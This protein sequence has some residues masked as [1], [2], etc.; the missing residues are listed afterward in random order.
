MTG[1]SIVV[2]V[3]NALE[4]ARKCI[5]SV[6]T[7]RT[8]ILFEVIVVDNGS[9]PDVGTWLAEER[10]RRPNFKSL[11][12]DDPLGFAGAINAGVRH[13]QGDLI[14]LLNSDTLVTDGWLDVLAAELDQDP[15]L[16]IVGP[17]TNRCG[18]DVQ[19]DSAA[20]ALKPED[21]GTYAA[22][23]QHRAQLVQEAQ[24]LAFFCV[25]LRRT[26]WD[27]LAGFDEIFRTGNF[28]DDDFCL[29][30]RL[31][32]YR[33]AVAQNAFVF[34]G[35]R[36]TFEANRLNHGELL[37]NNR[38]IFATRASRW[39]R[40]VRP[41]VPGARSMGSIS[42]IVPVMPGRIDG[43]RDSL[44][45]LANQTVQGFETVVVRAAGLDISRQLGE[46]AG[47]LRLTALSADDEIAQ[48]L[49]AGLAAASGTE[50]A[51]LPASDVYYP[52]HLEVLS[53]ALKNE[54]VY[55]AWSVGSRGTVTFPDAEPGIELGD[56]A[57]LFCW[58]HRR[59]GQTFDPSFGVFA[60]WAFVLKLRDAVKARYLCRVTCERSPDRPTARYADDAE[61]V[62]SSFPVHNAWQESQREQ[63]LDGVRQGNWE[64]RLIVSRNHRARRAREMLARVNAQELTRL[65]TRLEEATADIEP[66]WRSPAKPDILLFSII[67]WTSLTQ[68]PHHFA[69]GLAGRGHRVF[70]V[71]IRL[72]P[73]DGVHGGNLVRELKA[74]IYHLEL[75]A[76]QDQVYRLEW[77]PETLEA[78]VSCFAHLRA[79]HGI[80][81]A[82]QLVNFPR[83]EPLVTLLRRRF[84]WPVVYDCLDDQQAFAEL[85]GHHLGESEKI[86]LEASSKVFVSGR[87]LRDAIAPTRP[88][89]ILIPN[90]VDFEL[91]HRAQAAGLLD[92]LP[93]PIIGFFGAFADWLDLDWMEAA[94]VRFPGWSFVYIGREGFAAP[95]ARERWKGLGHRENVHIFPQ[96]APEKLVQYLAPMDVCTMPFR[97]IPVA[98]SM[99]A[100]K[101]Y[102]Y[103]AAG[104]P[105]VAPSL[106]ETQPLADLGLIATYRTNGESFSLLEDAVRSPAVPAR[107][108][109]A[110]RNTWSQRVEQLIAAL[111]EI[112]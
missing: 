73:P 60:P 58:L 106:P 51:Y 77:R 30:A 16:G 88:D 78:M 89:A 18:H 104:K 32:G 63:F 50:I 47:R 39:S 102:E 24:R 46:F 12:F 96:A 14:A 72:R 54:A 92:D 5:D 6:Y 105:V 29:R 4:D 111:A 100:V 91:F 70:W 93:R 97:D 1:V 87:V 11:H 21:A 112:T 34:H 40:T 48:L 41:P 101:I 62:M 108:E 99:N 52:F 36:R 69:E 23:I 28:E 67:E 95:T 90:G 82:W 31:A 20:A 37:A 85:Y 8:S 59:Q 53:G 107:F 27:Q 45:S 57:P 79:V 17:V 56:W 103:L 25:L 43:L 33:M 109:F 9:A 35:E 49:N 2:P 110:A 44:A 94:A 80:S 7:S 98:R 75:P 3:Y 19:R 66:V 84:G 15:M 22:S 68:R 42:V 76:L 26:L 10:R 64:D 74:G 65:R 61:R 83:W 86:L 81:S 13:A 55:S 38:A 71:D